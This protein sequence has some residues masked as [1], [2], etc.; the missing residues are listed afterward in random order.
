[1]KPT[2]AS[3]PI[4]LKD[5]DRPL[6][7]EQR[8]LRA[9]IASNTSWSNTED[10][11]AR[12]APARRAM[13]KKF[14]EQVDP[15]GLLDPAERAKRAESARKAYYQGLALKSAKARR[16]RAGKAEHAEHAAPAPKP[17]SASNRMALLLSVL[18]ESLTDAEWQ[19][20]HD[21]RPQPK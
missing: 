1:M 12:T 15:D 19:H 18:A 16:E 14:E 2:S 4:R 17:L 7:P 6:T 11:S 3:R 8:K 10:R 20:L 21:A 9:K 5:G 13:D